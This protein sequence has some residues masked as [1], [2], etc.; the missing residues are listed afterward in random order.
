VEVVVKAGKPVVLVTSSDSQCRWNIT[1]EKGGKLVGIIQFGGNAQAVSGT[2]AP[3]AYRAGILPDGK[4]A[5]MYGF[6]VWK[7][8]DTPTFKRFRSEIKEISGKEFTS[9]QGVY[10]PEERTFAFIVK[11]GAK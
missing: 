1:V 11:P 5:P 4:K 10:Q 9:L 6:N 7:E 2:D 8:E 3:V